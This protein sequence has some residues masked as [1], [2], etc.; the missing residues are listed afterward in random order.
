LEPILQYTNGIMVYQEQI[1]QTAQVLAGYTLGGADLLRRAMGKKKKEEMDKQRTIFVEGA[2]K[3]HGIDEKKGEEIFAIM[4]KFAMY[5]FNR[6][7][8][9]AYSVVAYQTAY[10]KA[11][12]PAEFMAAVLSNWLGSI[13]KI[14]T[15]LTECKHMGLKVLGP[16]LNESSRDFDVNSQN[17]IRFG[18]GAIKGA[19]EAAVDAIIEERRKK[20][21]FKSIW[22]FLER[23][24]LRRVNKKTLESLA[25]AGA[26]DS[27]QEFHRAQFFFKPDHEQT[28]GIE[29]LVKYGS[30]AQIE[31]N[32]A[33]K[34]LFGAGSG[35]ATAKPKLP[36]CEPWPEVLKLRYE[37]E[38][39][40]FFLS[41]H[42]LDQYRMEMEMFCKPLS[43]IN[44]Y[45]NQ[46]I[47]VGGI[48]TSVAIRDGKNGSKF[49]I[50][51]LEDYFTE[52][53][54]TF[55][56]Q[57]FIDFRNYLIQGEFLCIKGKVQERFNQPD[58][59]ELVPKQV[60]LLS[61]IKDKFCK[62]VKI[63]IDAR[64]VD[65]ELI[66]DLH[67]ILTFHEGKC[68]VKMEI[69]DPVKNVKVELASRKYKV[70]PSSVFLDKVKRLAV[71]S[72]EVG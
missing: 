32:S 10:L 3:L 56:N 64:K 25:Y 72:C 62:Q 65:Q 19:G 28:T 1:M 38:V 24:D 42:P 69:A 6:S 23:V 41:G 21:P 67:E 30:Q 15:F 70:D 60:Q 47:Q 45:P 12:Y 27:F 36:E 13:E 51:T 71:L 53:K 59:Y 7:H 58:H 14:S 9:A 34:S 31:S 16:D 40:G 50:I 44:D 35:T 46:E 29:K 18:L 2:K 54:I 57:N 17:A 68:V 66:N 52:Q 55:F 43:A 11:N 37:K 48:V 26:F 8:S 5:G 63:R 33:Q 20:G 61:S 22:D 49:A 4:E 39:L